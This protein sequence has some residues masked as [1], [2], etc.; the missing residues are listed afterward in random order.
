MSWMNNYTVMYFN[1]AEAKPVCCLLNI[2]V[3][4]IYQCSKMQ[5]LGRIG[6]SKDSAIRD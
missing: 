2:T 1:L 4:Y 5:N 3:E 6:K